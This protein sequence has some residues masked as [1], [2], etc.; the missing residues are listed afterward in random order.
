MNH[1]R[2]DIPPVQFCRA[3]TQIRYNLPHAALGFRFEDF[4]L[5]LG[6]RPHIKMRVNIKSIPRG[7]R[8]FLNIRLPAFILSV[9]FRHPKEVPFS[10]VVCYRLSNYLRS[11]G[12]LKS[13]A[14]ERNQITSSGGYIET[15]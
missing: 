3:D 2:I 6:K 5:F 4:N 13:S 1:D 14:C 12:R 9:A 15:T 11:T 7:G 8:E 10:P